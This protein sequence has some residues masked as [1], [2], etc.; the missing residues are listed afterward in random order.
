[1]HVADLKDKSKSKGE[2]RGRG[3]RKGT[4]RK[5]KEKKGHSDGRVPFVCI[6]IGFRS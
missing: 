2:R 5:T 1:L 6:A 4:Q 3:G